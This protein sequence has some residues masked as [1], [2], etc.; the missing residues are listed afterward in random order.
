MTNLLLTRA[1]RLEEAEAVLE[2][3][4]AAFDL[5]VEAARPIF[6]AD[7]YY[8]ISHK[9]VLA[10]PQAGIVSCLTVVPTLLRVGGVPVCS[11]GIAGVATRPEWQRRG[12]A[13]ALLAATVP[14]L[15]D[16]LAYPISLL[17]PLSAP[18]YR[19]FGWETASRAVS[20]AAIPSTLPRSAEAAQVRPLI[21]ADW[22]AIH[23]L[24]AE[25]T[26]TGTGACVR[27][28]RR[29]ALIQMEVPGRETYVY[30]AAGPVTGYLI[31]E[32]RETLELLEMHGQTPEARRGLV[33]CLAG[34]PEPVIEWQTSPDLLRCFD[35]PLP[36]VPAE[37]GVMLRIVNLQA[38]LN[39]LHAALYAPV[40]AEGD[41]NADAA[42]D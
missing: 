12:H 19:R 26:Q 36:D 20:W 29:W 24:H 3:L 37:P 28:A 6:Y 5:N 10:L 2:T 39:A 9:R 30:E 42:G 4:C 31:C 15:W 23:R 17:H 16:E 35:L 38:A 41:Y 32:R 22:P 21:E 34:Q 18:F 1:A 27:D 7:P 8:D 11:G 25:M 13:A 40:L 33:G 14:A